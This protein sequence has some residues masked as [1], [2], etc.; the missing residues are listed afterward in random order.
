MKAGKVETGRLE[1]NEKLGDNITTRAR[2]FWVGK[3]AEIKDREMNDTDAQDDSIQ[4]EEENIHKGR[5]KKKP[6]KWKIE[7]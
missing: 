2:K 3:S 6:A 4:S 1:S 5:K 7:N